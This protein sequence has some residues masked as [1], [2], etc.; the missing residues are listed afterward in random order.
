MK[1]G[2]LSRLLRSRSGSAVV[3]FAMV[4]PPLL[5]IAFGIFEYARFFWTQEA[6]EQ[7]ATAAARCMGVLSSSCASGGAYS[8][9][10]TQTYISGLAS[11]WGISI[12][13]ANMTLNNAAT[14]GGTTG[15]S[16]VT[17]TTDFTTAVPDI[18]PFPGAGQTMTAIAC[19]PNFT[20]PSS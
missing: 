5:A 15:F 17:L 4:T 13:T 3:D 7:T 9:G 12:P 18:I 19:F 2:I 14:C 8:S 10:N 11:S 6:L 16:Q 1:T 20:P